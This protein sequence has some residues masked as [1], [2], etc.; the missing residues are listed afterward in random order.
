VRL[1][2]LENLHGPSGRDD[3]PPFLLEEEPQRIEDGWLVVG[4]QEL[5]T[6]AWGLGTGHRSRMLTKLLGA[7]YRDA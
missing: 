3:A 2:R 4:N 6:G 7:L 5:G 1:D